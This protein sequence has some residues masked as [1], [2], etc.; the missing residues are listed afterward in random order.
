MSDKLAQLDSKINQLTTIVNEYLY[1][2]PPPFDN[3]KDHLIEKLQKENEQYYQLLMRAKE[4]LQNN[5]ES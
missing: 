4:L 1:H 3:E 5:I 2:T